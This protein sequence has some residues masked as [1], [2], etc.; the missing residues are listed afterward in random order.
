MVFPVLI[1]G[2]QF[3][4]VTSWR[5]A[6]GNIH[7]G[8]VSTRPRLFQCDQVIAL[9]FGLAVIAPR[10]RTD[11]PHPGRKLLSQVNVAEPNVLRP[12]LPQRFERVLGTPADQRLTV[13]DS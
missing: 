1:Y 12:K 5:D 6:K 7:V 8:E 4:H 10:E 13:A 3:N 9:L 11:I 2:M